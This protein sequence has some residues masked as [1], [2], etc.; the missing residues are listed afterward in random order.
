M[1]IVQS[2]LTATATL[3]VRI[4]TSIKNKKTGDISKGVAKKARQKLYKKI[5]FFLFEKSSHFRP[6]VFKL[7]D[8]FL[9][10]FRS[11]SIMIDSLLFQFIVLFSLSALFHPGLVR[12]EGQSRAGGR[13]GGQ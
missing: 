11:G 1:E 8:L 3:Y 6:Q 5:I 9:L 4:Q 10:L 7:I 12:G 13:G 2:T